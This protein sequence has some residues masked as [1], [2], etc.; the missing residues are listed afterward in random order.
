MF[1]E[2]R[3]PDATSDPMVVT[4]TMS[5][6]ATAGVDYDIPASATIPSGASNAEVFVTPRIDCV[7]YGTNLSVVLNLSPGA[8]IV[9]APSNATITLQDW[10]FS[11]VWYVSREGEHLRH[12]LGHG[13]YQPAKSVE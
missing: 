12:E 6:T 5:G 10:S 11:N 4:Y 13:L 1:T 2:Y 9:T 8:Y 3:P 7:W